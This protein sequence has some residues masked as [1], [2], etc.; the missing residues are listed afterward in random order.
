MSIRENLMADTKTAMKAKEKET[1]ATLRLISA[2]IKDKD[3]AART[4]GKELGDTEIMALFQTMIKQRR[5][6]V[7]MYK[8]GGRP[9]L[10]EKE[11]AEIVVIEKYLPQQL[12]EDE[13]KEAIAAAVAETGAES[14]KDMG[15]V[16]GVLKGK[17]V[18]QMDF[19]KAG[20]LVKESFK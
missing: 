16:M 6:S 15:K 9:E 19:G 5:E 11:E 17:Y 4:T 8:D 13:M 1:L 12:S 2:A 20:A 10:A 3:I 18:G 14:I 7:K